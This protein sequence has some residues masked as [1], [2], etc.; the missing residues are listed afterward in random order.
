MRPLQ[1]N[2]RAKHEITKIFKLLRHLSL[3]ATVFTY[4]PVP[5]RKIFR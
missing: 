5:E 1:L 4:V 2:F 3:A